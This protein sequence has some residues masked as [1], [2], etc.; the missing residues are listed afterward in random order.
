MSERGR[1][2]LGLREEDTVYVGEDI[3]LKLIKAGTKIALMIDAPKT[4][5]I[6]RSEKQV[7]DGEGRT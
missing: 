4:T 5:Q 3:V 6:W 7:E 1:L 2:V